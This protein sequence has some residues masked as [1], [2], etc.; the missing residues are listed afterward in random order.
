M[1]KTHR[2]DFNNALNHK[3]DGE[4]M[5][6]FLNEDVSGS[7]VFSIVIFVTCHENRINKD[8]QNNE[9]VKERL[10]YEPDS[11]ISNSVALVETKT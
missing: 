5:A 8:H 4:N 2:D 10:A 11:S 1:N 9:I 3:G 6:Y 7:F